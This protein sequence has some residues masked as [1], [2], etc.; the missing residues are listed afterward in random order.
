[1]GSATRASG[2]LVVILLHVAGCGKS[3]AD[4][5]VNMRKV[6][7][8]V[9]HEKLAGTT[10]LPCVFTLRPSPSHE[11]PRI[12][13][14]KLW[15]QG[16]PDGMRREQSVL[17]AKDNIIKVKKAFQGRVT[18]PGYPDNRYNATLALTG[19]RSSDSGMYRCEV[20]VGINDEQDTVPLVVSGVVF[21]YRAAHDRYALS[22][23]EAKRVC[24]ENSAVIAT[25]AQLQ[26]TFDDGYDNCDAGWLSDQT[27]RY[28]IQSPRP[29]CYGDREDSPGVRNYGSRAP[30]DLFDVY[31]Y[32]EELKG[33]VFHATVPEKLS[34]AKASIHCHSLGG[35]LATAG[36][37]YLA[38]QSGLDRCDPGWLADG[39]VRYPI[40]Q[41]R[42]NCGGDEPGV[43]T[44]YLNP[45]RTGF[46]DTMTPFDAYCY[47]ETAAGNPSG[48]AVGLLHSRTP[49]VNDSTGA[50]QSFLSSQLSVASNQS[51]PEPSTWTGLVD[52]DKEGTDSIMGN[53]SEISEEHVVIHLRS[54][55]S[56]LDWAEQLG[57]EVQAPQEV[58]APKITTVLL[59][60]ALESLDTHGGSAREEEV[61][62]DPD[63][64]SDS[65]IPPIFSTPTPTV[66]TQTSSTLISNI[67]GSFIR[68]WRYLTGSSE[69]E[70][71][72]TQ[73]TPSTESL[74]ENQ[75]L[76]ESGRGTPPGVKDEYSKSSHKN[77]IL[78]SF[79]EQES[80][81]VSEGYAA[82]LDEELSQW[83]R[84]ITSEPKHVSNCEETVEAPL[85]DVTAGI[86]CRT[87]VVK[88]GQPE[89][90]GITGVSFAVKMDPSNCSY[91]APILDS[92]TGCAQCSQEG[93]VATSLTTQSEEYVAMTPAMGSIPQTNAPVDSTVDMSTE[94]SRLMENL[95]EPH[96]QDNA[97]EELPKSLEARAEAVELLVLPSSKDIPDNFSGEGKDQEEEVA[98]LLP[99]E[100][101]PN[102]AS[103]QPASESFTS[104]VEHEAEGSG[105]GHE[106]IIGSSSDSHIVS[107]I[108]S[109]HSPS[110]PP[111]SAPTGSQTINQY[112][113]IRQWEMEDQ[114]TTSPHVS[115]NS[116]NPQQHVIEEVATEIR[117]EILFTSLPSSNPE[118]TTSSRDSMNE[119][120]KPVD[121]S[122]TSDAWLTTEVP[123]TG[124]LSTNRIPTENLLTNESKDGVTE[125]PSENDTES[126]TDLNS[127][128]SLVAT[129]KVT[130]GTKD[131][132]H[133]VSEVLLGFEKSDSGTTSEE[134]TILTPS[135][136]E[137]AHNAES[138]ST[139]S[140][141]V[142]MQTGATPAPEISLPTD[143]THLLTVRVQFPS[144]TGVEDWPSSELSLDNETKTSAAEDNPCQ[145]NPC[146][147]GGSCL[148]E[149]KGYSCYCPQGYSGESCEIDIDDCQSNPC[150]NGGT[151]ID[152]IDSF[153]CLCLPSYGGATCEKDTEGC[154]HNWR[155]F[156]GHCYRAFSHRH[157]WEDAEKDCR[158]HRGHLVSIH[159]SEEQDFVNDLSHEN[160]WIGLNDRTVEDD[161]Q[162]T[163][164]M[165]LQYENWRENQPDN[166]FAGGEDCVVMIAHE[167]GKW[168]D[169]PCNYNLPY[170][171]KKGTVLCGAPP[172]V[173]NA[174]LIGRK[175]PHY[176]IH[177]V[178]RYQC[179]DGFLQRHVP[180]AKCR[181]NGKWDRPKIICTKP[182]RSHRYRRHH[183]KSRHER[184][185]H[186]KHG[187]GGH[188][189]DEDGRGHY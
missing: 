42:R 9:I 14:T 45:N 97:A 39:S 93:L 16:G 54:E 136:R 134:P 98:Y 109:N 162:W 48:Q 172:T 118:S 96:D 144:N 105:M 28:P 74:L 123:V 91:D 177:S 89:R 77:A 80:R 174:F 158:E 71:L 27:V 175:R 173:D 156:H 69:S 22:F 139:E 129:E 67:M 31:C 1:M 170:I 164:N 90:S 127:S 10:F 11:P 114:P 189:G 83:E 159:S 115:T 178:V 57:A 176:D 5:L 49:S 182:R 113:T 137:I 12:K 157:T 112:T 44:V 68:P 41:P 152:E 148:P 24:L 7:H 108:P 122:T 145:T 85:F 131:L 104:E 151:C 25:P 34:L 26:A 130:F 84:E 18:L 19:L 187:A 167:N 76:T 47:R 64:R 160:T 146:L 3:W 165:A 124:L 35:Q 143:R 58:L 184:R 183:H 66:K 75:E 8:Q 142:M 61:D 15:G 155:K 32:A 181:A 135:L 161:F 150:Q 103:P 107:E 95:S 78:E 186:R 102:D 119:Y 20:V 106:I 52:L 43:R 65:S 59:P 140:L 121:M 117:E 100:P 88:L 62:E 29:G 149:G 51:R 185:K 153:V 133:Y 180:T 40:N 72:S 99:K 33:E 116:T 120:E 13:W 36:Q 168:N 56:P 55:Q 70:S 60:S 110:L 111:T 138:Q 179:A 87:R 38:W 147:H 188:H 94:L 23:T 125:V 46:P 166:F 81:R 169:V 171:C 4:P 101:F 53:E 86:A 163:D 63:V 17:V 73:A 128:Y 6:T 79:G 92:T 50:G 37:L 21:H 132:Q 126:I 30:D 154:E 141:A 82:D 2:L